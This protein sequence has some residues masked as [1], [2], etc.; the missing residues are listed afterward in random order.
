MAMGQYTHVDPDGLS[1]QSIQFEQSGTT[2]LGLGQRLHSGMDA[3]GNCWGD[4]ETGQAFME[5][6]GE[7]HLILEQ[8]VNG[9]YEMLHGIATSLQSMAQAYRDAEEHAQQTANHVAS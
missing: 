9:V 7:K 5:T 8:G 4:D 2:A 6:Y 3:I 1:A